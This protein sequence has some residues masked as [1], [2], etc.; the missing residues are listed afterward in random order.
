[1]KLITKE[2]EAVLLKSPIYSTEK[3]N[4]VPVL[5]KFFTPWS[6]WTWSAVE[7]EKFTN[8]K[9]KQDWKFFGLVE[10]HEKELGYW[11]LSELEE[12]RGPGGL[13]VERDMYFKDMYLD[14]LRNEVVRGRGEGDRVMP[15]WSRIE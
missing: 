15:R 10:G 12:V 3:D 6:N 11:L 1:M 2:I 8:E 7:G 4:P 5:V 14:K 13:R 9:G